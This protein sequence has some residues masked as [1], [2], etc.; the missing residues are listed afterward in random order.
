MMTVRKLCVSSWYNQN[1]LTT[2]YAPNRWAYGRNWW[3]IGG[4]QSHWWVYGSSWNGAKPMSAIACRSTRVC[5][6]FASKKRT[7]QPSSLWMFGLGSSSM[8]WASRRQFCSLLPNNSWHIIFVPI[9]L[10]WTRCYNRSSFLR[11]PF[12]IP[13]MPV[14][15]S[16]TSLTFYDLLLLT[17]AY[18]FHMLTISHVYDFHMLTVFTCF[19]FTYFVRLPCTIKASL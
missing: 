8:V 14:F 17:H 18:N 9:H 5:T 19:S 2:Q 16:M 1:L 13:Y 12:D 11:L 3:N 4:L 7:T 10:P 6:L 15:L